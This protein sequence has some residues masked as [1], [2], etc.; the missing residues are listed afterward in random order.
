[1]GAL[2]AALQAKDAYL[3]TQEGAGLRFSL[4]ELACI[5]QYKKQS[6]RCRGCENRCAITK[7]TFPIKVEEPDHD[8]AGRQP[9]G[10]QNVFFSGNRC[11]RIYNNRGERVQAGA[12]LYARKRELLFDR[13]TNLETATPDPDVVTTSVVT[14]VRKRLRRSELRPSRQEPAVKVTIGIPRALNFYENYPFWHTLFVECG[15]DV[16]LSDASSSELFQSGVRSV[17]SENIC[18]PAKLLHGHIENLIEAGV[19]RIFYPMVFY[20]Q[21]E[22]AD[23]HNCFNCPVVSGY[24]DVVASAVDPLGRSGI[25]FDQPAITFQ[26]PDLLKKTCGEYLA[27]LGVQKRAFK[28]AFLLALAAQ[29]EYKT[30]VRALGAEIVEKAAEQ[31]RQV[32]VLAGH[33]Y[34]LDP[35]INHKIP[36][37]LT[38]M[39]VDVITED[40]V[41]LGRCQMLPDPQV[42]TQWEYL[43]RCFHAAHWVGG[44]EHAELAQLNS[45]GCGPDAFALDEVKG[46]LTEHG[47]N[48]TVLRIDEI[49]SIGSARPASAR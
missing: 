38:D 37:A 33:P 7:L 8:R 2:G 27:G 21:R 45:F 19:D 40:A 12:N 44:Q 1:M 22:F 31:G 32:V 36:E 30:E 42:L 49:D 5:S 11:E 17:M 35:L 28:R 25:P 10:R 39:G 24:P 43:N 4:D 20:E 9:P 14:A 47:K 6:L 34:H 15:L 29:E 48:H 18:F 16:R 23:A 41:P 3:H 46:I 26:N 13:S